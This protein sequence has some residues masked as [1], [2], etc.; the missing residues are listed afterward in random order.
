MRPVT[1][2]LW[3]INPVPGGVDAYLSPRV[4]ATYLAEKVYSLV[5]FIFH[6]VYNLLRISCG[7]GIFDTD[8]YNS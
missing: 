4:P 3:L 6:S 2:T 5:F 7:L 8:Y 1:D